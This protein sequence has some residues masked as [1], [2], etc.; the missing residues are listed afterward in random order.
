[1]AKAALDVLRLAVLAG[2]QEEA[3]QLREVLRM[4]IGGQR[5]A[6]PTRTFR[7]AEHDHIER[8]MALHGGNRTRAAKALGVGRNTLT[9]KLKGW[10]TQSSTSAWRRPAAAWWDCGVEIRPPTYYACGEGCN[11]DVVAEWTDGW[12]RAK[13]GRVSS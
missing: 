3:D 11:A 2:A 13:A 1:M 9:R 8:V 12:I 7:E 10:A 4:A 5:D 6:A